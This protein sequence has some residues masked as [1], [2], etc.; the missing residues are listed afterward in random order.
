[1]NSKQIKAHTDYA[2]K[3]GRTRRTKGIEALPTFMADSVRNN[4]KRR[5]TYTA[6]TQTRT[7]DLGSFA[8]WAICEV[9]EVTR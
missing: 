3:K 7:V 1:M 4:D 8:G 2:G 5:V 9:Q 6:G